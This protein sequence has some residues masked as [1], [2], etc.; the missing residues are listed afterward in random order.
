LDDHLKVLFNSFFLALE[1]LQD[2]HKLIQHLSLVF[3][4]WIY[5]F[6]GLD[7]HLLPRRRVLFLKL[8]FLSLYSEVRLFTA[9]FV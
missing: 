9:L 7:Q 1:V 5:L 2:D 6:E 4:L 3:G 8:N